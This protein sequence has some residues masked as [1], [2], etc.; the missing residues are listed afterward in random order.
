MIRHGEETLICRV[1]LRWIIA[2]VPL[3]LQLH[4]R[5]LRM[6]MRLFM[7]SH[8]TERGADVEVR[9]GGIL[10]RLRLQLNLQ[11]S[12]EILKSGVKLAPSL[13]KATHVVERHGAQAK[14]PR[15]IVHETAS[16]ISENLSLFQQLV[17]F[18]EL[19]SFHQLHRERVVTASI[20]R[21]GAKGGRMRFVCESER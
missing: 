19:S 10:S 11:R 7:S 6:F 3:S 13:E 17:R 2:V 21:A 15:V 1:F 18:V 4:Y 9:R 14:T 16:V 5:F 12:E 20:I 8:L